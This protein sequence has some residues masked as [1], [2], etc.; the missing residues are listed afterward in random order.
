V[1]WM[2]ISVQVGSEKAAEVVT[3]LFDR[4]GRGGA[5]CEQVYE[6]NGEV[7]NAAPL[8]TVKTFLSTSE[9]DLQR[10][11][12]LKKELSGVAARCR[13]APA[14]IRELA[15]EDWA[16][17]WKAFFRPQRIGRRFVVKLPEQSFPSDQ[18]QL[19]I[20]LEPGMAFGTG[21]HA[22][23]RMC[24]V[25]LEELVEPG[26]HILDM[27]TGSGILAIGAAKLGARHV[28]ALDH[29]PIAVATARENVALNGLAEVIEVREGSL[30]HLTSEDL[31]RFDGILLNILADVI[32]GM[33][34]AGITSFLKPGGWLV[35]SGI[36]AS[37]QGRV[38]PF[39]R[40]KGLKIVQRYQEQEWV[41]LSAVRADAVAAPQPSIGGA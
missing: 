13:C 7:P 26:Q 24:L 14:Q 8:T 15:E 2:E 39:F 36:L 12:S 41:T 16:T 10:L 21:L 18:D 37:A 31:R 25:C 1:G 19:L 27:G 17:A 40:E 29:D 11:D 3:A 4:Y 33:L 30:K 28:L 20:D 5:V 22:T 9:G 35:A 38:A 23:T 6:G 32:M 34:Q